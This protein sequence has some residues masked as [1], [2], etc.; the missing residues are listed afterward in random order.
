MRV[1]AVMTEAGEREVDDLRVQL[2]Q[3]LHPEAH[4]RE[5]TGAVVLDDHVGD[6]DQPLHQLAPPRVVQVRGDPELV[7]I[8]VVEDTGAIRRGVVRVRLCS[9]AERVHVGLVL[10][11]DHLGAEVGEDARRLRSRHDPREVDHADPRQWQRL[12]EVRHPP[13]TRPH[14]SYVAG[15]YLR[16]ESEAYA[17]RRP[18]SPC[19]APR[20]R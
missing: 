19:V 3:P 13:A 15:V 2:S 16:A 5:R 7:A 10:H 11:A 20:C 1:A 14:V 17:G 12:V 4:A 8:E 9:H 18:A 6:G